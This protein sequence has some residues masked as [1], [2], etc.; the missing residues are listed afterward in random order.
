VYTQGPLRGVCRFLSRL[1]RGHSAFLVSSASLARCQPS[2]C[3]VDYSPVE[4][5]RHCPCRPPNACA[6]PFGVEIAPAAEFYLSQT[7]SLGPLLTRRTCPFDSMIPVSSIIALLVFFAWLGL[8]LTGGLFIRGSEESARLA[9]Q[10]LWHYKA[11]LVN[12]RLIA[13]V[14][15]S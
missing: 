4:L 11:T 5:V 10:L 6:A 14:E 12:G 7:S 15:V 8:V 2:Y 9:S 13:L 1:I 3:H